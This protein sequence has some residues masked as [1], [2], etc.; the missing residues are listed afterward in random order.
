MKTANCL[1]VM[2]AV[3]AAAFAGCASTSSAKK[4]TAAYVESIDFDMAPPTPIGDIEKLCYIIVKEDSYILAVDGSDTNNVGMVISPG[5][6]LLTVQYS[7]SWNSR[8]TSADPQGRL[9]TQTTR[10]ENRSD[11][12]YLSFTFEEGKY[13]YLD[14]EIAKGAA[15]FDNRTIQFSITETKDPAL[16]EEAQKGLV[17]YEENYQKRKAAYEANLEKIEVFQTF[18]EANPNRFEGVWEGEA[19]RLMN[20]FYIQYTFTGNIMTYEGKSKHAGMRTYFTEGQFFFN[21]DTII[22]VPEKA[23][24]NGK[25][26][27]SQKTK[28]IWY[29]TVNH[30]IL[31]L[32]NGGTVGTLVFVWE[33]N[34]EFHKI[35]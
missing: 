7:V 17:A 4:N 2:F 28:Y 27:K 14:Y 1:L 33:T 26:V 32:E 19:K 11:L 5:F 10:H 6:H 21:E 30:N 29:Y 8:S 20:T 3:L 34:G 22:F 24:D 35:N 13:Y 25:E 16:S 12:I 23:A 18:M 9:R 31:H 15:I